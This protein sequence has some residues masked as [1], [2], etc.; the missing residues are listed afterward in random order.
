MEKLGVPTAVVNTEPFI[1][2]SKAM[3]VAHGIPDYPF[4]IMPHPIAATEI[5]R[6]EEWAD[7]AVGEVVDILLTGSKELKT[8]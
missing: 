6:L 7:A 5:T 3:A 1:T 8:V 2:S 4:V